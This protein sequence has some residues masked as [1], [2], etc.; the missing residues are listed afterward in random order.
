MRL[1][2]ISALRSN[3]SSILR[4]DFILVARSRLPPAEATR[5]APPRRSLF[6][7]G[8]VAAQGTYRG[9]DVLIYSELM[10]LARAL[11]GHG[12]S[13]LLQST[14]APRR[15]YPAPACGAALS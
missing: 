4:F 8:D 9:W 7:P 14:T 5:P 12:P 13:L 11:T 15:A 2:S 1:S 6:R 10:W 3:A